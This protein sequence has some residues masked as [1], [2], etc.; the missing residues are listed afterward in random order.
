MEK[1]SKEIKEIKEELK[2]VEA[3]MDRYIEELGL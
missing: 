2:E 1:V 3:K